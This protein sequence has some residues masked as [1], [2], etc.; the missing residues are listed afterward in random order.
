MSYALIDNATLTAVQRLTGDIELRTKDSVDCDI[1]AIENLVEACL[2]YDEVICVDDYKEQYRAARKN[3]FPFIRFIAP[4]DY[5]L[6]KID[7]WV[8]AEVAKSIPKIH[9]GE[10]ADANF[11][12]FLELLKMNVVCTWDISSSVYYLT[13]KALGQ[14]QGSD[15]QKYSDYV[16]AIFSELSDN[17][18]TNG[19]L[20]SD[21]ELVDSRGNPITAG[22]RIPG[23]KWGDGTQG[24][25]SSGLRYFVASLNWLAYKTIYYAACARF[26]WA[27]VF[28]HPIRHAFLSNYMERVGAYDYVL[29]RSLL[30]K[31]NQSFDAEFVSIASGGNGSVTAFG[32]PFFAAWIVRQCGSPKRIMATAI[33]MRNAA[34]FREARDQLKAIRIHYDEKDEVAASKMAQKITRDFSKL[35]LDI[36]EKYGV[37]TAQGASLT[38]L[39]KCYNGAAS[40]KGWPKLPELDIRVPLPA[41]M[42]KSRDGGVVAAYRNLSNDIDSVWRLGEVRDVLGSAVRLKE[43]VR[44]MRL[45]VEAPKFR[46]A[47]SPFKSPM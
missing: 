45:G 8:Q 12:R 18:A 43:D 25:M 36:R 35:V 29:A 41:F 13:L 47:H 30:T 9:G 7:G 1:V 20:R 22:Y 33:E 28:L 23:A 3:A 31:M 27:D 32:F 6:S 15:A 16:A 5:D 44:A 42:R 37:I 26:F 2:F 24:G 10:F 19:P 11:R 40:F 34:E 39:I 4:S 21:V 14:P 38:G 46:R 17:S